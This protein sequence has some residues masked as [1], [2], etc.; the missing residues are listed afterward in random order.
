MLHA[1]ITA[2]AHPGGP[3]LYVRLVL[4]ASAICAVGRL[5]PLRRKQMPGYRCRV[6]A[7]F[8]L[9]GSARH[10]A[11]PGQRSFPLSPQPDSGPSRYFRDPFGADSGEISIQDFRLVPAGGDRQYRQVPERQRPGHYARQGH[12]GQ[13]HTEPAGR[14][15][16]EPARPVLEPARPGASR[17][18]RPGV[19]ARPGPD[20]TSSTD[21]TFAYPVRAQPWPRTGPVLPG[22]RQS[23]GPGGR[24]RPRGRGQ[25]FGALGPRQH[26]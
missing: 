26:R 14:P 19:P 21:T 23:P 16:L 8:W 12:P 24:A 1:I 11:Q 5:I 3:Y 25:A 4:A 9:P 13:G 18:S 6:P 7:A 22:W 17:R 20:P 15:V 2:F 10:R